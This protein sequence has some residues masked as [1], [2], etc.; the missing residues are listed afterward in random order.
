L[1]EFARLVLEHVN[2]AAIDTETR[3]LLEATAE[4]RPPSVFG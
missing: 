2:G 1:P 4:G 3:A